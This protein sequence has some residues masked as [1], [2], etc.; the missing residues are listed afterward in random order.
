MNRRIW[1]GVVAG[2][3]AATLLFS[4]G[5]GAYRAGQDDEVVTRVTET[6]QGEVVRVVGDGHDWGPGR[7]FFIV[8]LLLILL[9]VLLARGRHHHRGWHGGPGW[10]HGYGPGDGWGP[11]GPGAGAG[12]CGPYGGRAVEQGR[13]EW[14]PARG[15]DP[16]DPAGDPAEAVTTP[17]AP[18]DPV[19]PAEP[20]TP[21]P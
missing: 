15:D 14:V 16:A 7:G 17:A 12:A 10:R 18:V 11:G 20:P 6:S 2:V 5:I 13:W 1:T 3:L 19:D 8:P 21:R 9:I 4:V